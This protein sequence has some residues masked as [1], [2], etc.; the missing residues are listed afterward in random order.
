MAR[1]VEVLKG[2]G[3]RLINAIW[4]IDPETANRTSKIRQT[5]LQTAQPDWDHVWQPL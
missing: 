1:L 3:L 5:P 4:Q 2:P